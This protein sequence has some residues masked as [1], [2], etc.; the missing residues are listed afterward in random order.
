[1]LA[2]N[3]KAS[4]DY[5]VLERIEAGVRLLGSEVKSIREGK[6]SIKEAY[7]SFAADELF[8]V[9]AHV[10][11]YKQAHGRNHDPVRRRKLL[12]HRRE[13]DRLEQAVT[14]KGLTLVPL[15][16]YSR[17]GKI[18]VELG[19]CRGKKVRDRRATLKEREQRREMRRAIRERR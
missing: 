5:Q 17:D 2:R 16:V 13:L 10:A 4:H 8:L 12:M 18:K 6:I 9:G 7:A 14:R 11:E 15:S 3:R 19:I 1:M